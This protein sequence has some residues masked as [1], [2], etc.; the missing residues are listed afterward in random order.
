[1]E[2]VLQQRHKRTGFIFT[3]SSVHSLI[4]WMA[5]TTCPPLSPLRPPP[6]YTP[7]P[8]IPTNYLQ[9]STLQGCRRRTSGKQP[10]LMQA[11]DNGPARLARTPAGKPSKDDYKHCRWT[12]IVGGSSPGLE[13]SS[14]LLTRWPC[15]VNSW[16]RLK[17]K[18]RSILCDFQSS[19]KGPAGGRD[20]EFPKTH[21]V[22][23]FV[24]RASTDGSLESRRRAR[25]T[26]TKRIL[27]PVP[28]PSLQKMTSK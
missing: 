14:Y 10:I 18:G 25:N 3:Q 4:V 24:P 11:S 16:A 28:P 27:L 7:T 21:I 5:F 15:A 1:M 19:H 12:T 17:C 9:L 2:M 22:T 6:P 26:M 20:G 8:Q 13:E 23:K